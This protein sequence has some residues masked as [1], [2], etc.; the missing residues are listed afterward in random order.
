MRITIVVPHIRIAG[1]IRAPLEYANHLCRLGHTVAVVYPRRPPYY[2]QVKDYWLG[3]PGLVRGWRYDLRYWVNKAFKGPLPPWLPLESSLHRV[4]MLRSEFVPDADVILAV[5]W[6]TSEWV[7]RYGAEKG[8]KFYRIAGYDTWLGPPER[9]E[10]TWRMSFHKVAASSWLKELGRTRFGQELYGP[11]IPGVNFD[12]FYVQHKRW[13]QPK[14]I[15]MLYHSNPIKGVQDGLTAFEIAQATHSDIRL[16]MFGA[17]EPESSLPHDVE[18]HKNPPQ[19]KLREIYG[20]CDIWL[21]P[22]HLEGCALVPMEAMAC[23]CALVA[24]E[25]GAIPD[26][27]IPG[28]TA[29]VSPPCDPEALARNLIRLLADEDEL[30]RIARAGY[31][32]IRQFTWERSARQMENLFEEILQQRAC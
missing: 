27:T 21:F 2:S 31:E 28:T 29:L 17:R 7:H 18:F 3:W 19:E 8:I 20:L 26:Y 1:G 13:N 25:V 22:N 30:K 14:R 9:V 6:T 15:G 5:D 10:A 4:P 32:Y 12:Q 24:T 16:V 23:Q 11:I